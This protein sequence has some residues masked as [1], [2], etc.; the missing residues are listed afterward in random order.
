MYL[1]EPL[2]V[3]LTDLAS[4]KPAPGGGSTAALSG[5]MGA[6]LACMVA[7]L[8]L[9]KA[10]YAAVHP[11][12]ETLLGDAERL[13][14]RFQQ[15][16]QE[17]I[18]AYSQLSASFKLPRNTDEAR[19]K[20]TQAVQ[21]NLENAARVPLEMVECAAQLVQ[22]CQRIAVLGNK[23]VLSDIA[24][25]STLGS[26]AGIGA[27]WMVRVNL[28]SMKDHERVDACYQRLNTAL[29]TIAAMN[30]QVVNTVGEKV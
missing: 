17:D 12:M 5:A 18:D 15:L 1:D 13:R 19:A 10:D 28:H 26:S 23:N 24:V 20:R 9:N 6:A 22:Y 4:A 3:Y 11:E 2:Q 16:M 7:R 14:E 30:Q 29:A 21:E 27:S 8:T 25:A